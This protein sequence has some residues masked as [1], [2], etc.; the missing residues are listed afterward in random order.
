[1][2]VDSQINDQDDVDGNNYN[3]KE[4]VGDDKSS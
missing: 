4:E 2:S 3:D 1:M